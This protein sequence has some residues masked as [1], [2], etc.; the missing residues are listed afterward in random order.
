MLEQENTFYG[1]HQAE[2]HEKYPVKDSLFILICQSIEHSLL[3][4]KTEGKWL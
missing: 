3:H 2:F 1:A 4:L